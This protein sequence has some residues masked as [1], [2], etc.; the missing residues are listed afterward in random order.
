MCDINIIL[1]ATEDLEKSTRRLELSSESKERE[2]LD[3]LN[4]TGWDAVMMIEIIHGEILSID[5]PS[6]VL[7]KW[8]GIIR[9][10]HEDSGISKI[11]FI[12]KDNLK[13]ENKAKITYDYLQQLKM[14]PTAKIL[15]SEMSRGQRAAFKSLDD[16]EPT[17]V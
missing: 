3:E 16:Y 10:T 8:D 17:F 2:F 4:E 14:K 11:F 7:V 5:R 12:D 9:A 1:K 13:N 15:N 6:R